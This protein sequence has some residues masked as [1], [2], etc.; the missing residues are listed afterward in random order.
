MLKYFIFQWRG[1]LNMIIIED[2]KHL[3]KKIYIEFVT[4]QV[5]TYLPYEGF[6]SLCVARQGDGMKSR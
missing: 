4:F 1:I 6:G 3:Y 2:N 5:H